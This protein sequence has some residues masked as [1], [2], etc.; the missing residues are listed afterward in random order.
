VTDHPDEN[1]AD[2]ARASAD[3]APADGAPVDTAAADAAP[4]DG[5]PAD[6]AP[7]DGAPVDTAAADAASADTAGADAA[8][9]DV[10]PADVAPADGAPADARRGRR[11]HVRAGVLIGVLTAILGFAIA[12]QVHSNSSSDSLANAREDDLIRIL[13]DQN[14]RADRLNQQIADLQRTLDE[15]RVSGNSDAVAQQQ[16]EQEVQSLRVLLGTVSVTGP[17]VAITIT[18]PQHKLRAEDLLDVVEELRGA[19]A[20]SLQFGS[21]RVGTSTNFT[22]AG[23]SVRVDGTQLSPPY[24]VLAIGDPKTLD[25]AL[26]IPGGV[27][28]TAR[29]AG[30][31]AQISERPRVDILAVRAMPRPRY[32]TPSGR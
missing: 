19:G 1:A 11:V 7:A 6:G 28:A 26:S 16:A 30:G 27:A 18:D 21:V 14:A 31:D 9:A 10:A 17:G 13:D 4:A 2:E 5:A 29:N 25:T 20:E 22:D 8:L 23:T 15:L 32:M 12:V 24:R 3:A